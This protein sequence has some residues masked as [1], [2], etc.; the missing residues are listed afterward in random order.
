MIRA[1][2]A[3]D[4]FRCGRH[5]SNGGLLVLRRVE[6]YTRQGQKSSGDP[7]YPALAVLTS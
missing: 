7:A 3:R 4:M 1:G 2:G 5:P 6:P